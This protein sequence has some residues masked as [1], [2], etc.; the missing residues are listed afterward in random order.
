MAHGPLVLYP[1]GRIRVCKIRLVSTGENRGNTCLLFPSIWPA[2]YPKQNTVDETLTLSGTDRIE[3][4]VRPQT[5]NRKGTKTIKTAQSKTAH[6]E[7]QEVSP[8]SAD[9]HKAILKMK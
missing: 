6:A 5:Q 4:H 7:S 9:G 1:M 3:F 2:C 8:F